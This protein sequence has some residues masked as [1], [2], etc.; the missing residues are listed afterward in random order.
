MRT[1]LGAPIEW[2][3]STRTY[4]YS[5]DCD[6]LPL[7][8]LDADEA[9]ALVMAGRAFEAWRGS[10]LGRALTAA[11]GKIAHVVGGAVSLPAEEVS[12]LIFEPDDGPETESEHRFFAAA[13]EAIRRRRELRIGYR[14][15]GAGV[16]ESR[17]IHPL[18][19]AFMDHRWMLVAYDPS[20]SGMRNFLL[21]RIQEM[22]ATG[23]G[24]AA[25]AGF[26]LQ[27][28]LKGS[29][30]RFTGEKEHEVRIVFDPVVAPYVRERRWHPSQSL[31]ERSDGSI[32]V[33]LQ[34]NNL[35]D[36]RRWVLACGSHAEVLAP[37]ELRASL[38][39]E[40]AAMA[41]RYRRAAR[42]EY[43]RNK[44]KRRSREGHSATLAT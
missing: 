35:V 40:T 29:L 18:H 13:L 21:G 36:V 32:E 42:T 26:D 15:P 39:G 5:K 20:R 9:L 24:F 37:E 34:L 28:Y 31:V 44:D 30:G 22:K 10:P 7:L 23:K 16:P 12:D 25:P 11:L 38:R 27:A 8:R 4:F 1:D 14:K 3:P 2:E 19:L 6:L 17:V 41:E 43:V 33:A